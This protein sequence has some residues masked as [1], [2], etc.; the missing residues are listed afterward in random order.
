[1]PSGN[2]VAKLAGVSTATVSY[3]IN[4][5]GDKKVSPETRKRVLKAIDK[6]GY[7]PHAA[8]RSL[9]ASYTNIV[10][11]SF[12]DAS[13]VTNPMFA[14]AVSSIL[15]VTD[16]EGYSLLISTT[17]TKEP[18]KRMNLIDHV[19]GKRIDGAIIYDSIIN[20]EK[21]KEV[22]ETQIPL[23][24]INRMATSIKTVPTVC[25]DFRK[26]IDLA[27]SY[28]I[29][30]GH[31]RIGIQIPNR[32][33]YVTE[34]KKLGYK[35]ALIRAGIEFDPSIVVY[36]D[37]LK[38]ADNDWGFEKED[39][40]DRYLHL[41]N[42]VTGIIFNSDYIAAAAIRRFREEGYQIPEDISI[43]G[44]E[45][46]PEFTTTTRPSLTSINTHNKEIGD[47]AA[48]ILLG[49]IRKERNTAKNVV[50]LSELIIRESTGH[51]PKNKV[52]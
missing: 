17:K 26:S 40:F 28:L 35:D 11:V 21:L 7:R 25:T 38:P 14:G 22:Y 33:W 16:K 13:Y 44:Y 51:V 31:K 29:E 41:D 20:E 32:G 50:I 24:L 23:V 39:L 43:I 27:T 4:G 10:G 30:L 5:T 1:M 48:K 42:P 52:R 47:Q 46:L 6:L 36:Q 37:M 9:A 45:D 19:L 18:D 15:E 34:E 49:I 12:Y 3:V 8:A 2:D